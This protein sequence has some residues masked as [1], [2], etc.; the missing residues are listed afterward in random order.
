LIWWK[1]LVLGTNILA[2]L[3]SPESLQIF[4]KSLIQS[5]SQMPHIASKC[6]HVSDDKLLEYLFAE[7]TQLSQ[8]KSI[9]FPTPSF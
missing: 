6:K 8:L 7:E 9:L 4:S 1:S 3:S 5:I 2:E